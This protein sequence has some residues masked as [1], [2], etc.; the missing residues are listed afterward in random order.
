VCVYNL[1]GS[2]KGAGRVFAD[3]VRRCVGEEGGFGCEGY[4]TGYAFVC[5]EDRVRIGAVIL[6]GGGSGRR[7]G[8]VGSIVVTF[9]GGCAVASFVWTLRAF[10]TRFGFV[11]V[12][13]IFSS[14][15][16]W[17]WGWD[18]VRK[19]IIYR[20]GRVV[21]YIIIIRAV[22]IANVIVIIIVIV[23]VGWRWRW[24]AV[25]HVS[26]LNR[27]RLMI[28]EHIVTPTL[29]MYIV[30]WRRRWWWRRLW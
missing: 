7:W 6:R 28:I 27:R 14:V 9:G 20:C 23:V 18:T 26:R 21:I 13:L 25:Q 17:W 1:N 15:F 4:V 8:D 10:S 3:C 30:V 19:W 16:Y 12:R 11:I 22:R 2:G 5:E 29:I 24:Y